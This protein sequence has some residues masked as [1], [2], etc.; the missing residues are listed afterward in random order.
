MI[1][2]NARNVKECI[3]KGCDEPIF[4]DGLCFDCFVEVGTAAW[5]DE[6]IEREMVLGTIGHVIFFGDPMEVPA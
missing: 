6:D 1:P 5:D 4:R 3:N 2:H